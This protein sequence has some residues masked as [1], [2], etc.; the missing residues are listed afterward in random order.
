MRINVLSQRHI[1]KTD[2]LVENDVTAAVVPYCDCAVVILFEFN[3]TWAECDR[4]RT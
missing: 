2:W 3:T 1:A 4:D